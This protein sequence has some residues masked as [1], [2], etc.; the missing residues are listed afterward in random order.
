MEGSNEHTEDNDHPQ[1][2]QCKLRK[3]T[4]PLR[5]N[6]PSIPALRSI[7]TVVAEFTNSTVSLIYSTE[8]PIAEVPQKETCQNQLEASLGSLSTNAPIGK[9]DALFQWQ[10][11]LRLG[12]P[13]FLLGAIHQQQSNFFPQQVKE[14]FLSSISSDPQLSPLSILERP[15]QV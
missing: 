11:L 3:G 4:A 6:P 5:A 9:V 14:A 10:D 1:L 12:Q 15:S 8:P 7:S 13:L 2:A